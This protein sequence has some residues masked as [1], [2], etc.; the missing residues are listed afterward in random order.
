MKY[1]IFSLH[2]YLELFKKR[3]NKTLFEYAKKESFEFFM[4]KGKWGY[5]SLD[6]TIEKSYFRFFFNEN[7]FPGEGFLRALKYKIDIKENDIFFIS[8]FVS[9]FNEKII[10]T[11][12]NLNI[13]EKKQ[14]IE[15]I[16]KEEKNLEFFV[17]EKDIIV[18]L[19]QNLPMVSNN[20]PNKIKNEYLNNILFKEKELQKINNFM[21]N[22]SKILN[23]NPVNK[24]RIDLNEAVANF[25]YFYGMG[26]YSKRKFL[27]DLIKMDI[28]YYSDTEIIKG[29]KEFFNIDEIVEFSDI[30]DN[31]IYW[32]NFTLNYN[33]SQSIWVKKF[34]IFSKEI[35]GKIIDL[36]NI[37]VLFIF[38]QFMDENFDY[39]SNLSLFLAFNFSSRLKKKYKLPFLLFQKFIEK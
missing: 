12:V 25:L 17:F 18:K 24:V 31:S 14:L 28:F 2:G 30:K 10:E 11:E 13:G 36:E 38:D 39:G 27:S 20:F 35:L 7:E 9:L 37:R 3:N 26:K 4:D 5:L 23:L 21:I 34:E 15:E 32:F 6:G 8:K 1:I 29:L 33:D 22:S 16:K 19:S